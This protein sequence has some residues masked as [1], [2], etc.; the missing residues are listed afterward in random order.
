M[1]IRVKDQYKNQVFGFN[2]SSAPLGQRNDL[3]LLVADAKYHNQQN[4]LDMFEGVP[5]DKELLEEK[6][7]A[8]A[9]KQ[10]EEKIP[11][12]NTNEEEK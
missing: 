4:I 6:G 9:Q 2:N 8:F 10:N 7:N 5:D 11:T 3:H 12:S 1:S